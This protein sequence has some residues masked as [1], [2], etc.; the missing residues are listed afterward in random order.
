MATKTKFNY[1]FFTSNTRHPGKLHC[2][3]ISVKVKTSPPRKMRKFLTT[4]SLILANSRSRMT[5][6]IGF[7]R[8]NNA[9]QH[10]CTTWY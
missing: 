9:G 1:A 8:Q 10:A 7:S 3:V 2:R 5:T 4:T 6:A